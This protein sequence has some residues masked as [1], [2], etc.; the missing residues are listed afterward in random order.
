MAQAAMALVGSADLPVFNNVEFN[1]PVIVQDSIPR[2]IRIAALVRAPDLVE[3]VLRSDETAF[4]T[5]HFRAI[6]RFGIRRS[7][8]QVLSENSQNQDSVAEALPRINIDPDR[9]LYG[10]LLFHSGRFQR[11][12]GYRRLAATECI[13]ELSSDGTTAWFDRYLPSRLVLGDPGARDATIHAIQ[14]CVPNANLLPIGVERII[15][16]A[17]DPSGS[18]FVYA[19]ERSQEDDTFIYDVEVANSD[20]CLMELTK[21]Q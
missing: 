17:E 6:C 12:N 11:L 5:D 1:R 10:E 18:R 13:A 2:T 3:V 15:P 7:E 4:Q 21:A 8:C 20:G 16:G 14:A 9:D 19:R